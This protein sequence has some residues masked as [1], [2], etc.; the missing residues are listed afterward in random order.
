[1]KENPSQLN[2]VE[3]PQEPLERERKTGS[4]LVKRTF[5][6]WLWRKIKAKDKKPARA[7][8]REDPRLD[9]RG[10]IKPTI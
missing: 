1:M 9:L 7:K 6:G 10:N 8:P 4:P 3:L 5:P 2:L